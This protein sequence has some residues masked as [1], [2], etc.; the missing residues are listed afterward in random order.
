[1]EAEEEVEFLRAKRSDQLT[2][3]VNAAAAVE[4]ARISSSSWVELSC[5]PNNVKYKLIQC[6]GGRC[7]KARRDN[8]VMRNWVHKISITCL[9]SPVHQYH[10]DLQIPQ[11]LPVVLL[12]LCVARCCIW[13]CLSVDGG[14]DDRQ[15]DRPSRRM[16]RCEWS[17]KV[18]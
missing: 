17:Q 14:V 1:M 5:W 16:M 13:R 11:V 2:G 10:L 4:E 3:T 18:Q 9:A 8:V 12:L 15:W 7:W 6:G